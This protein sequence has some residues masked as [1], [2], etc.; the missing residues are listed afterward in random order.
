MPGPFA[1]ATFVAL[2]MLWETTK[3]NKEIITT[4]NNAERI[5]VFIRFD[6]LNSKLLDDTKSH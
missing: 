2:V 4:N 3:D 6:Y 1:V 5:T